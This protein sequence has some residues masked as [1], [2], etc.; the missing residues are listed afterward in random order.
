MQFVHKSAIEFLTDEKQSGVYAVN[1]GQGH[2]VL[3]DRCRHALKVR[4]KSTDRCRQYSLRHFVHHLCYLH[5]HPYQPKDGSSRPDPLLEAARVVL[6]LDWLLDRLLLDKDTPG[7]VEDMKQV[8]S[9]LQARGGDGDAKLAGCIDTVG[10][11]ADHAR[12]AIRHD[13][14]YIVGWIMT[15]LSD[16]TR[17]PVAKLVERASECKRFRWWYV[18]KGTLT[19]GGEGKELTCVGDWAFW[20]E[21][22]G[23][24]NMG[25]W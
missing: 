17:A 3:A 7:V 4:R 14:R 20:G 1:V 16:D 22:K 5:E 10:A 12:D 11:M 19:M 8:S 23:G 13:P 21:C 9:L 6:D 18:S 2:M 15:E 24:T 25:R